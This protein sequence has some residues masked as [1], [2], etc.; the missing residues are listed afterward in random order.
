MAPLSHVIHTTSNPGTGNL[1]WEKFTTHGFPK[2]C[3]EFIAF[4]SHYQIN[5]LDRI[6][7]NNTG[8]LQ[9]F[10]RKADMVCTCGIQMHLNVAVAPRSAFRVRV[11][12]FQTPFSWSQI[13]LGDGDGGGN[14]RFRLTDN[15][16]QGGFNCNGRMLT[17]IAVGANGVQVA[18]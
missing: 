14:G 3:L 18:L 12:L 2:E 17:D 7:T 13:S 9:P 8:V 5:E 4:A 15:C 6:P 16:P 1:L 10:W 11:I